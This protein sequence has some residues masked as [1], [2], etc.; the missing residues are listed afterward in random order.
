MTEQ[1]AVHSTFTIERTYPASPARVFAGFA[2]P[3]LKRRWLLEGKGLA[4][5]SYTAEFRVG[6]FEKS[7]FTF[8]GGSPGAPPAGTKFTTGRGVKPFT[9]R[10]FW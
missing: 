10:V 1:P 2:D 6:G 3:A 9:W 4:D 8:T 7:R 5:E